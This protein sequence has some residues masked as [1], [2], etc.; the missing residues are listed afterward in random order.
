M[1]NGSTPYCSEYAVMY[2]GSSSLGL[3]SCTAS[4]GNILVQFSPAN[5]ATSIRYIKQVIE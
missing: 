3:F 4:G 1:D 5:S 2:S